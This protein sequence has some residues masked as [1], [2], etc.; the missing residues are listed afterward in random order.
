MAASYGSRIEPRGS[1]TGLGGAEHGFGRYVVRCG[2][3]FVGVVGLSRADFD[4]GLLPGV[5][6]LGLG[7]I[8]AATTPGNARSLRVME[9]LGM[10]HSPEDCFDHRRVPDDD[11]LRHHVVH[12][13]PRTL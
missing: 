11:P 5:E 6:R 3:E 8:I 13:L 12:R 10:V 7:E 9:R 2:E 4:A 1:A